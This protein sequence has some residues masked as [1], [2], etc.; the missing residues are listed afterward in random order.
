MMLRMM[1]LIRRGGWVLVTW[2][3][4]RPGYTNS[5]LLQSLVSERQRHERAGQEAGLLRGGAQEAEVR[6][7]RCRQ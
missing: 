6:V 1:R 7:I 4:L 5:P 2:S 3:Q